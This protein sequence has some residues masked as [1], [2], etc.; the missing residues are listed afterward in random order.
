MNLVA[1]TARYAPA[2][3]AIA[4]IG[5][6]IAIAVGA[7]GVPDLAGVLSDTT[8]ALGGWV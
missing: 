7:I 4:G 6:A 2:G 8:R 1:F 3:V 5:L